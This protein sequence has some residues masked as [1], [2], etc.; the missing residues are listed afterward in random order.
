MNLNENTDSN[1]E[2]MGK[3]FLKYLE[4]KFTKTVCWGEIHEELRIIILGFFFWVIIYFVALTWLENKEDDTE[5]KEEEGEGRE[6]ILTDCCIF[7]QTGFFYISWLLNDK[8]IDI[9]RCSLS[10]K[11]FNTTCIFSTEL[12]WLLFWLLLW[13]TIAFFEN[14][15]VFQ[16]FFI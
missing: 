4:D 5:E 15:S 1:D 12:A 14:T 8:C 16:I 7:R 6:A 13:N 9:R 2:C 10:L 3:D 11:S